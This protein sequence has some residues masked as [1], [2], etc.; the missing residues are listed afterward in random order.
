MLTI[1]MMMKY[2]FR[3]TMLI[4]SF[5]IRVNDYIS[6]GKILVIGTISFLN[7]ILENMFLVEDLQHNLIS[8]SQL[9]D[10]GHKV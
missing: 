9:C 10:K 8:I 5:I 4:L 6:K 1:L 2:L 3:L 7:L